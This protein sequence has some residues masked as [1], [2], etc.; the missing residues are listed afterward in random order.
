MDVNLSTLSTL[1]GI[2]RPTS[3]AVAFPPKEIDKAAVLEAFS[4]E[5][6]TWLRKLW[7]D[8]CLLEVRLLNLIFTH[9]L[10]P[11]TYNN[12]MSDWMVHVIYSLFTKKE[13]DIVVILCHVII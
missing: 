11:I 7:A 5:S 1:L 4:H 10:F 12:D 9:N 6:T 2:V 3:Q 13:V 8:E